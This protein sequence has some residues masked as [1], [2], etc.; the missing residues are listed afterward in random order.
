MDTEDPHSDELQMQFAICTDREESCHPTPCIIPYSTATQ[1][2][3]LDKIHKSINSLYETYK[4]D[5]YIC[6]KIDNYICNQLHVMLRNMKQNHEERV[7]RIEGL[8][9][10]KDHFVSQF[11][12]NNQYFYSASTENFFFYDGINYMMYSEDDI[13]YHILSSIRKDNNLI[14]WTHRTKNNTMVK[15]RKNNILK[16]IPER[17]TI[18]SVMGLFYPTLFSNKYQVKHFLTIVG[19]SILRKNPELVYLIHPKYKN[20]IRELNMSCQIY[21]GSGFSQCFKH[22]YYEHEYENCRMVLI[23]DVIQNDSIWMPIILQNALNIICVAAHYS[24]RY[25]CADNYAA[26]CP[27][28]AHTFYLKN[29]TQ[30]ELV[31][32]F[33]HDYIHQT[34]VS[35]VPVIADVD[36][37]A[38]PSIAETIPCESVVLSTSPMQSFMRFANLTQFISWKNMQ[39]LWK[40]FLSVKNLP[41]VIFQQS[42]KQM[43]TEK[44]KHNYLPDEDIFSGI[45]SKYLPAI[46]NFLKFWNETII[47][48]VN[49]ID[50]KVGDLT[51]LY[52]TW[53]KDRY[54][55]GVVISE[56]Q[57]L[58]FVNYFYPDIE[59][60]NEKYLQKVKCVLWNRHRDIYD[61]LIQMKMPITIY[62]AYKLYCKNVGESNR[63]SACKK[64][65]VGKSYFD[66]FVFD[67]FNE[68]IIDSNILSIK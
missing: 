32:L 22:K 18:Q 34:Q 55:G 1:E 25:G 7:Y 21:I 51:I 36:A 27:D 39:Y 17:Y 50:L 42:L 57:I 60:E 62:D 61:E 23:N 68:Y 4:D 28:L 16:S 67:K 33:I 46:Q 53:C 26:V 3:P 56:T 52:K 65:I 2:S 10:E 45:S 13:L 19:D 20:L 30:D 24:T 64:L 31:D 63:T 14:S 40:Q 6:N 41:S 9:Q 43:L 47:E 54:E 5:K 44:L 38:G 58:D 49:E 59:I 37:S 66:K 11:L 15:I 35:N 8:T 48:D 29:T 12:N